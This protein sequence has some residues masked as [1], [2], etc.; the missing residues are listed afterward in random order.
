MLIPKSNHYDIKRKNFNVSV[1]EKLKW[2]SKK[3]YGAI[4][5]QNN[6]GRR[7]GKTKKLAIREK[8]IIPSIHII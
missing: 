3:I 6:K 5:Q 1:N 8:Y 4:P 7:Q 2:F